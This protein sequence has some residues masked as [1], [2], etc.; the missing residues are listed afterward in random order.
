MRSGDVRV[1]GF[2]NSNTS[3]PAKSKPNKNN[4]NNSNVHYA[5]PRSSLKLQVDLPDFNRG[6]TDMGKS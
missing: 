1:L 4:K 5:V 3:S 6:K 2:S